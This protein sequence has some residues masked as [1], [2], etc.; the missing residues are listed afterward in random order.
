MFPSEYSRASIVM[1]K[2]DSFEKADACCVSA[3]R[4]AL[5]LS[6]LRGAEE[7]M[8]ALAHGRGG[9]STALSGGNESETDCAS[10]SIIG[11][12][13]TNVSDKIV[14]I[15]ICDAQLHPRAGREQRSAIHFEEERRSVGLGHGQPFLKAT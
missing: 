5:H 2:S 9:D 15:G 4:D 3:I 11:E 12:V 6:R 13:Q 8:Q 14:G 1:S 10:E 7:Y